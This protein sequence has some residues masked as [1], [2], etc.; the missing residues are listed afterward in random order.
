MH[1][2]FCF[3]LRKESQVRRQIG[4]TIFAQPIEDVLQ[5]LRSILDLSVNESHIFEI[6]GLDQVS[7]GDLMRE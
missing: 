7:Y 2:G 1:P 6:G 4:I 5:Y 3:A